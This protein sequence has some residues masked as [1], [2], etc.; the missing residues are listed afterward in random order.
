MAYE[1]G[2][3]TRELREAHQRGEHALDRAD[4]CPTCNFR[5]VPEGFSSKEEFFDAL[6]EGAQELQVYV[7]A[8][9]R[10]EHRRHPDPD[11]IEC[12]QIDGARNG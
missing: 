10:G 11:C 7:D 9:F 8:H 5:V 1:P 12:A 2:A 4:D 3:Y 6:N